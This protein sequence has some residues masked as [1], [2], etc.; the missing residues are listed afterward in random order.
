MAGLT[1]SE[2]IQLVCSPKPVDLSTLSQSSKLP[3]PITQINGALINIINKA[4]HVD[5]TRRYDSVSSLTNDIGNY[6]NNRPVTA[7]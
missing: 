3:Y 1:I 5:Q 2:K 4:M 7:M 6:L